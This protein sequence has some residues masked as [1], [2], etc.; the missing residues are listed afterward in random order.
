MIY[1]LYVF[2]KRGACLYYREWNRPHNAL[3]AA[4][5]EDRKLV[6]G[7]LFSM[8]QFVEKLSPNP[9]PARWRACG[10]CPPP[11]GASACAP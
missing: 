5:E 3:A 8:K 11:R 10:R 1:N 7:L 4:P 9:Y 2:D 6:F